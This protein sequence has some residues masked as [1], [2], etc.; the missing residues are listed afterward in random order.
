[1]RSDERR[2]VVHQEGPENQRREAGD[3]D[4]HPQRVLAHR[5]VRG[6]ADVRLDRAPLHHRVRGGDLLRGRLPHGLRRELLDAHVRALRGRD[7]R[8]LR[9]H[10]RARVHGR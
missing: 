1:Y 10:D 4:G 5:L 3:P 6:R 8:G 2:V 7:R 9:A